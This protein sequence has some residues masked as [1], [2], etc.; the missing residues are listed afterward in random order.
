MK[1]LAQRS[2][3]SISWNVFAS[4]SAVAVLFV[5]SIVLARLLPVEVFGVY[6]GASAVIGVTIIGAHFGLGSALLHRAPETTS[7]QEAARIHFTLK[8]LFTATWCL[9]MVVGTFLFAEGA[10]RTALLVLTLT[11]AGIQLAETPRILLVRRVAHRR[12][13]VLQVLTAVVTT[14]VAI[15]LA[16]RGMTLWALLSTNLVTLFLVIAVLYLWR[17][18]WQPRLGWSPGGVRYFLEFGSRVFIATGL[19]GLLD[20]LD[21]LWTRFYLGATPLGFY[22]RAHT[23][24]SYP[25]RFLTD[26]VAVV[27]VGAYAELKDNRKFLSR[28]FFRTN[29]L[30][31]R[32]GFL[33]AGL[34]ALVAPEFVLVVL[35]PKWLPMLLPFRLMLIFMMLDPIRSSVGNLFT[36]VG[37]PELVV[38]ARLVQLGV[39]VLGLVVLSP[40]LG[41][42]GVALTVTVMCAAGIVQLL[43]QARSFVTVSVDRVFRVP[44]IALIV[45]LV[46][47]GGA[48]LLP[49]VAGVDWRTAMVKTIVF[50]GSF[51]VVLMS[52]ERRETLRLLVEA[53]QLLGRG[54][55]RPA[56]S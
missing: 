30:L 9:F 1:S 50:V 22:S 11:T 26:P 52:L 13:A 28:A 51:G 6:V 27:M 44:L 2:V 21:D 55:E 56:M 37:R 25:R 35:G 5:R 16:R 49:G 48:A 15:G 45:A 42:I 47:A 41:I 14:V 29:A 34:M 23:F 4:A 38:R 3:S 46:L 12:L 18:V 33:V 17:P 36:A 54:S 31:V 8:L 40:R 24:A 19:Q 43:W 10:T 20:R 7:E 39:L 53:K 32:V